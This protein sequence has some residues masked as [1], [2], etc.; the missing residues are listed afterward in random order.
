[1]D[2]SE[3]YQ[4]NGPTPAFSPDGKFVAAAVES[5]CIIRDSETLIIY[6]M[7]SCMD[8]VKHIEWSPTGRHVLCAL[9]SRAVAQ[10]WDTDD[11]KWTCKIDGGPAGLAR[12]MWSATGKDILTIAEFNLRLSVW[13]LKS[14]SC[15]HRHGPKH[16]HKGIRH[17]TCGNHLAVLERVNLKDYMAVYTEGVPD[18]QCQ[19]FRVSTSDADDFEWSPDG[20]H[21]AVCDSPL[22]YSVFVYKASD[23]S[24]LTQFQLA[25]KGL[26][27][28]AVQWSASSQFLAIGTYDNAVRILNHI[29]WRECA[30]FEHTAEVTSEATVTFTE[31][32]D[33]SAADAEQFPGAANGADGA[34]DAG[35]AR[36]RYKVQDVPVTVPTVTPPCNKPNPAAGVRRMR[37]SPSGR[38]LATVHEA[39]RCAL[40]LWDLQDLALACLLQHAQ[41][42]AAFE[43]DPCCDK[44]AVCTSGRR[45]HLWTPDGASCVH[46]PLPNLQ[47]K[48][49]TWRPD[50]MAAAVS[51]VDRFCIAYIA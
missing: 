42:I 6:H 11:P 33:D 25:G 37:M 19:R 10:V 14:Q 48:H 7:F 43:W 4:Y 27:V 40:W 44:L 5:K 13:D 24:C 16:T 12:A 29:T 31:V 39:Q 2:F 35:S 20:K 28:R 38:F 9:Q 18:D 8:G 41:P 46:T 26:G 45:L 17:S 47:S 50:G 22:C 30:A 23:G 49:V 3:A 32:R 36:W 51:D 21:I 34:A 15:K 1:M